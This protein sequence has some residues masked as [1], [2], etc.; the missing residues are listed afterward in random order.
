MPKILKFCDNCLS[1][2]LLYKCKIKTKNFCCRKCKSDYQTGKNFETLYDID[3]STKIKL[4]ISESVSGENNP[5]YGNSW[6]ETQRN[7]HSTKQKNKYI[8]DPELKYK[9]GSAN[10]G[11]IF[12]DDLVYRM[13]NHR[14]SESYSHLHTANTKLIIGLKSKNKFTEEYKISHRIIMENLGY[15]TPIINK[16]P[17][18]IYY[19]KS[20]W[21]CSMIEYFTEYEIIQL[22]KFGMFNVKTNTLGW[23]RDHILSRKQGYIYNI[24]YQLLRHPENLQYISTSDNIRKGFIDRK[25]IVEDTINVINDLYTKI[26][27]F[28]GIWIEHEFCLNYIKEVV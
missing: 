2:I 21:I 11:K 16:D 26:L 9:A 4:K 19:E 5:N 22:N 20:N 12:S 28:D 14:T 7:M 8:E 1:E 6:D 10:R 23:V 15:W 17:Y 25:M 18:K 27:N 3:K 24:P 13:H